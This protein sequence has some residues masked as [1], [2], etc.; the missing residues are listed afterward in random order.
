MEDNQNNE[1]KEEDNQMEEEETITDEEEWNTSDE[2]Y[3][4]E[5]N[6]VNPAPKR[7]PNREK[8]MPMRY[9]NIVEALDSILTRMTNHKDKGKQ[10]DD[11]I[12]DDLYILNT[13][14]EDGC[15]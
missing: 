12:M 1:S 3:N 5:E 2:D 4:P 8:R 14:M 15:N 7:N 10:W 11:Q 13:D 6:I 9:L